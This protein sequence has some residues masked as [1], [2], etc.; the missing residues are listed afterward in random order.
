MD[1]V[2]T[3]NEEKVDKHRFLVK[4]KVIE[5]SEYERISAMPS[6]DRVEEVR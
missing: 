5:D 1:R 2:G 3:G 6:A 4:S